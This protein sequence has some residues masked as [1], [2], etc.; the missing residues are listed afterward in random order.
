MSKSGL[1]HDKGGGES[2]YNGSIISNL[3]LVLKFRYEKEK[4]GLSASCLF[5]FGV[6]VRGEKVLVG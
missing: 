1:C 2:G 5:L 3:N 4:N 6:S